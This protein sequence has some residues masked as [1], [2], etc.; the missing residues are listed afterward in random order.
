MKYTYNRDL[1]W[2]YE[3]LPATDLD[4]A[5]LDDGQKQLLAVAVQAGVYAPVQ[6]VGLKKGKADVKASEG[7][8][9]PTGANEANGDQ[10]AGR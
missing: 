5:D 6:P 1:G 8:T 2:F 7:Q 10:A 4:D 3:G 9:Q